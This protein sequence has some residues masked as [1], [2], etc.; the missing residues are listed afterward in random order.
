MMSL[1]EREAMKFELGCK[2]KESKDPRWLDEKIIKKFLFLPKELSKNE[3]DYWE[4]AEKEI[5]W[6]CFAEVVLVYSFW[7]DCWYERCW[8]D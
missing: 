4:H 2:S 3:K 6:L 7:G 5:R 1:F 8:A